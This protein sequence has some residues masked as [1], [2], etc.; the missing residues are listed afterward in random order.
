MI[1]TTLKQNCGTVV[2]LYT[3]LSRIRQFGGGGVQ[4]ESQSVLKDKLHKM[5]VLKCYLIF[6]LLVNNDILFNF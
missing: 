4:R 3:N 5:L 1:V 2:S 6:A